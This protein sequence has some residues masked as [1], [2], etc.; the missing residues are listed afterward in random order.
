MI[1][2]RWLLAAVLACAAVIPA[3]TQDRTDA[4]AE[5]VTRLPEPDDAVSEE[6]MVALAQAKNFHHKAKVHLGDGNVGEAIAAVRQILAVP[7]PA[8][9]AEGE[10]VRVDARA[11]LAKLL[12]G[13]GELDEALRVTQEGLAAASRPSFF[14]ANLWTVT[15]EIHEARAVTLEA[16]PTAAAEARRAAI[17][18]YDESI[19]IN[20][21]I[22]RRL[23]EERP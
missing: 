11:L 21:A 1:R 17:R 10:D 9:A 14:V 2:A 12:V 16:D 15:G 4:R 7:F 22:Q 5:R 6:L 3:C 8:S 23:M 18:A 20:D 13:K 19:R